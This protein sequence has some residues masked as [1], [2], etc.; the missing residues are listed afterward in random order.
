MLR[1]LSSKHSHISWLFSEV[2]LRGFH[3]FPPFPATARWSSSFL[4]KPAKSRWLELAGAGFG[5]LLSDS[6]WM[7]LKSKSWGGQE[8][9][10]IPCSS[11][12]WFRGKDTAFPA[13]RSGLAGLKLSQA[14]PACTL[15]LLWSEQKHWEELRGIYKW[16]KEMSP[17]DHCSHRIS[18]W[19]CFHVFMSP[20]WH[21]E[22][23]SLA[24]QIF[25]TAFS[26]SSAGRILPK[27]WREIHFS[28]PFLTFHS[29]GSKPCHDDV[30]NNIFVA[31]GRKRI[32]K[33]MKEKVDI[34]MK[35][36]VTSWKKVI[37]MQSVYSCLY[38]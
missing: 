2:T 18:P 33:Y 34:L 10:K 14:A 7:Y 8:D 38:R 3:S 1:H 31:E 9:R 22:H 28:F 16:Q 36:L 26:A 37:K 6:R 27:K 24:L 35:Y 4:I 19:Y 17:A 15:L 13:N 20:L 12:R 29:L 11:R 32:I 30:G 5:D 21:S 23:L 25:L